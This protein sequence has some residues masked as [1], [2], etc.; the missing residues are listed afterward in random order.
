M[1]SWKMAIGLRRKGHANSRGDLDGWESWKIRVIQVPWKK[2]RVWVGEE[3]VGELKSWSRFRNSDIT[4]EPIGEA[5]SR[6]LNVRWTGKGREKLLREV[7]RGSRQENPGSTTEDCILG[8]FLWGTEDI[9]LWFLLIF[10]FFYFLWHKISFMRHNWGFQHLSMKG[11]PMIE[12]KSFRKCRKSPGLLLVVQ[13][14]SQEAFF[15]LE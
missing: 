7:Q 12:I 14:F 1:R 15:I 11:I 9:N 8:G 13:M 6:R 4:E 2:G 10:F 5:V 3:C